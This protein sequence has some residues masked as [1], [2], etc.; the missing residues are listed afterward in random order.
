MESVMQ[1]SFED[2]PKA[3][4]V[5]PDPAHRHDDM[6]TAVEAAQ[7]AKWHA[8]DNQ[9]LVLLTLYEHPAG[10]TD[11]E[12]EEITGIKQTS[13]GKRRK[14]CVDAK[15]VRLVD[16]ATDDKWQVI[17]RHN[18]GGNNCTVW[19]LNQAGRDYLRQEGRIP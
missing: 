1:L 13:I 17:K 2:I 14:D 8:T 12:L 5:F 18:K 7:K 15:P 11:F 10:L 6:E 9:M 4:P 16:I 19:I 3:A